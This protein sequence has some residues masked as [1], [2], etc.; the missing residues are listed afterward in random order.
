MT[1]CK[2]VIPLQ[3]DI[4]GAPSCQAWDAQQKWVILWTKESTFIHRNFHAFREL[5]SSALLLGAL[6]PWTHPSLE[7]S[8]RPHSDFACLTFQFPHWWTP[9]CWQGLLVM[10]FKVS[11]VS[12]SAYYLDHCRK[13]L[14]QDLWFILLPAAGTLFLVAPSSAFQSTTAWSRHFLWVQAFQF[15]GA[16]SHYY[17]QK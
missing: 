9:E 12:I 5:H 1:T 13:L 3:V 14:W 17:K 4:A 10:Y 6:L 16:L 8:P 15:W 2:H 11:F 7:G